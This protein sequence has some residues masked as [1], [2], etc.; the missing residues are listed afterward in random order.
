[1]SEVVSLLLFGI[2]RPTVHVYTA[3]FAKPQ[4]NNSR[5]LIIVHKRMGIKMLEYHLIHD[6]HGPALDACPHPA[7]TNASEPSSYALCLVYYTKP[8]ENRF[9]IQCHRSMCS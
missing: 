9:C 1:M 2:T 5:L 4:P 6:K 8:L 7:G 3:L